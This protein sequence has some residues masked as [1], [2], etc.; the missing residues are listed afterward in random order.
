[1][2]AT[3][4]ALAGRTL[5]VIAKVGGETVAHMMET[6]RNR[7]DVLGASGLSAEVEFLLS[8]NLHT[9]ELRS[10]VFAL[11]GKAFVA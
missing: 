6:F 2:D 10:R 9:Y 7:S 4:V 3:V 1:M 5:V 11:R 8:P